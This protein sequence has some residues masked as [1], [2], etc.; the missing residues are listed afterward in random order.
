MNDEEKGFR[1]SNIFY[2]ILKGR[3]LIA[4]CALLG[5]I[6]G[7]ILSGVKYLR[8]QISKEYQITSSIAV[9]AQTSSGN[10]SST[11]KNPD[12]E[13]VRIAQELTDTAIYVIKSQTTLEAAIEKANLTGITAVDIQNNLTLSQYNETQ[14]IEVSL[15]WRS[16]AEGVRIVE[17]INDT[18]GEILLKTLKVGNVSVVTAPSSRYIFGGNISASTWI[19]WA[20]IGLAIGIVICIL[21]LLIMPTFT[22]RKDIVR[23]LGLEVMGTV[24]QDKNLDEDVPFAPNDTQI[25]KNIDSLVNILANRMERA[26]RHKLYL[27]STGHQEGRTRLAVNIAGQLAASEN[28]TLLIDCDLKN[29]QLSTLFKDKFSYENTLNALYKGESDKTD[30]ITH[31]TGCLDLL[32]YILEDEPL[33]MN[34]SL[35]NVINDACE[36]YD[37][38]VIDAAPVGEDTEVIKLNK[39]ADTAVFVLRFDQEEIKDIG[40]AVTRLRESGMLSIGCIVNGIKTLRDV[41]REA[42][43]L[44]LSR[45]RKNKKTRK[46]KKR[47]KI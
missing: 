25:K 43:Q 32:P 15:T 6:I 17:A 45:R 42:Q 23:V 8:G 39:V 14:I 3:K 16:G 1:I 44:T 10:F 2:Y 13:D 30:A 27:T 46:N 21:K 12:P 34:G 20:F 28:K 36:G 33:I 29:P 7:I 4:L 18:A 40:D 41:L 19:M 26:D 31:I 5:L 22:N 24:V 38:V 47:K 9:I 35:L 11:H 37:Y